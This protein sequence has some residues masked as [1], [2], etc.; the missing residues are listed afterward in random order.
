MWKNVLI[1]VLLS[2]LGV[3]LYFFR[4]NLVGV[5]GSIGIREITIALLIVGTIVLVRAIRHAARRL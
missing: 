1:V 2:V 3:E 5:A 4:T